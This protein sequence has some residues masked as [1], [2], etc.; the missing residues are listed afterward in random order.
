MK[1]FREW[2]NLS[3]FQELYPRFA[4]FVVSWWRHQME[5]F[6]R[7][8]SFVRGIHR[9]PVNSP[10]KGQWRG[11]VMFSLNC[12]W[13]KC[14]VN[15]LEAGDSKPHRAHCDVIVMFCCGRAMV[16]FS[17]SIKSYFA[18][19]G[20]IIQYCYFMKVLVSFYWL[21]ST[22][23]MA[24]MRNHISSP[25]QNQKFKNWLFLGKW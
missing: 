1:L 2:K 4:P 22:Q 5:V 14:W 21:T 11:A 8:W 6:P 24:W 9:S 3:I 25:V 12:A 20:E 19:T 10:H 23:I 18:P 17:H 13:I 16:Y 7:H 15:N